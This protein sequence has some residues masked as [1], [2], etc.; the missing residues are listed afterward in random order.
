MLDRFTRDILVFL[1]LLITW[2][3]LGHNGAKPDGGNS[4]GSGAPPPITSHTGMFT[5]SYDNY[6]TNFDPNEIILTHQNVQAATFGKITEFP[7][8]AYV[9]AQPLYVT[10]V[11]VPGSA[12]PLNMIYVSTEGDSVYAYDASGPQVQ[13]QAPSPIWVDHFTQTLT[14]YGTWQPNPHSQALTG[15][16]P[17]G[18]GA[19]T[20]DV[21][22]P[23]IAPY[24]G[25]TIGIN[26]TPVIDPTTDTL[27]VVTVTK[28]TTVNL[29]QN[30]T[31]AELNLKYRLMLHALDIKTGTEKFGGPVQIQL[32]QGLDALHST[33]HEGLALETDANGNAQVIIPFSSSCDEGP[34]SGLLLVYSVQNNKLVQTGS[35]ETTQTG[36]QAGIWALGGAPAIGPNGNIYVSTGNGA[37]DGQLNFG[38]SILKFA[39]S[40]G[41][42]QQTSFFTPFDQI[43]MNTIQIDL[44][45]G[46]GGVMVIPDQPGITHLLVAG[47]KSG[48]VYLL[49][50]DRLGGYNALA[51]HFQNIVQSFNLNG[52]PYAQNGIFNNGNDGIYSSPAYYNGRIY[53]APVGDHIRSYQLTNGQV[54]PPSYTPTTANILQPADRSNWLFGWPGGTP[55]ISANT[56]PG[57]Y[58]NAILWFV[59]TNREFAPSGQDEA[60]LYAFD[61]NHMYYDPNYVD[62]SGYHD[63][64]F[65]FSSDKTAGDCTA[66]PSDQ[67]NGA[68][69]HVSP[70]V[71]NGNVYFGTKTGVDMYGLCDPNN[72]GGNRCLRGSAPTCA[73]FTPTDVATPAPTAGANVVMT[74]DAQKSNC[75][76]TN[77]AGAITSSFTPTGTYN[78]MIQLCGGAN[79]PACASSDTATNTVSYLDQFMNLTA[80]TLTSPGATPTPDQVGLM[81][82]ANDGSSYEILPG[83]NSISLPGATGTPTLFVEEPVQFNVTAGAF[84]TVNAKFYCQLQ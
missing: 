43:N 62:K 15:M 50:R 48:Q 25:S 21:Q 76:V 33:Q 51:S 12:Q 57:A 1:I 2:P 9:Y 60:I 59:D 35:H 52:Q 10:N 14:A 22:C 81:P 42:L 63:N 37:F 20:A 75:N 30:P 27:Y 11:L 65:L 4:S 58:P 64:G 68:T 38:C 28:D 83:N 24:P 26:S 45:V 6:R 29:P 49:N 56:K 13:G 5:R 19:S 40:G 54:V 39:L 73:N 36:G 82:S 66:N 74:Y 72:N 7:T 31:E 77:S 53:Y 79:Y 46:S 80:N 34:Y 78:F 55:T 18:Q 16:G 17:S 3:A 69:K 23:D 41:D 32:P 61:A 67:A 84:T 47:G 70:V 8:D 71:F 44:D